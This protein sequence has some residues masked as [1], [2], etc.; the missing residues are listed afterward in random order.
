MHSKVQDL[1]DY[2]VAGYKT[3]WSVQFLSISMKDLKR[4]AP[5][6]ISHHDTEANRV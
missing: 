3:L 4:N 6:I 5:F 1:S 2:L